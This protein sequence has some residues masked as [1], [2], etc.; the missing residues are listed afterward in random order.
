[1][2]IPDNL[3][4]K[5]IK[6]TLISSADVANKNCENFVGATQI[7]LGIAGPLKIVTGT[8]VEEYFLPLTTTE[9][10]LIA[11]VN[12]GCKA[13]YQNGINTFVENVGITRAPLFKT[14]G[15]ADSKKIVADLKNSL[16]KL[17]DI[18]LSTSSHIALL[19]FE[20][21][22]V[23]KNLWLRFSFDTEEAMGLNMVTKASEKISQ[24]IEDKYHVKCL[25]ISG[26]YC[27]DKK[28]TWVSFIRGRGKKVWAE[29]IIDKNF[30]Q[31]V[32]KTSPKN[33]VEIVKQKS[34]LGS[35]VAGSLGF[36]AHFANVIAALFL[37]TG[38]DAGHISE[39]SMGITE[40][41]VDSEGNLYF[42]VYLPS[43]IIGTVGG[44]TTLPTQKE[45]LGIM[46]IGNSRNDALKFSQI[47]AGAVLAG[48]LSLTAAL[49]SGDLVTAHQKLGKGKC[50]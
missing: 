11:S 34:Q 19:G 47:I 9:G 50:P 43:L 20:E 23:G 38:Q 7:P 36:N 3:I 33:I 40:A 30:C 12:R 18:A 15:I 1:M 45:S 46:N 32:L 35:I 44:G 48:E 29:T 25:A 39:S 26:N 42:S 28:A 31:Q 16:S 10:A 13:T 6:N 37:S 2:T 5:N 8:S 14:A 41:E 21:Q 24:Y 49:A 17:N 4:L 27:S 22:I